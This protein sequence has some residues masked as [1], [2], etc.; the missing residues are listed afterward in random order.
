MS[1]ILPWLVLSL[2]LSAVAQEAGSFVQAGST[3]VSAMMVRRSKLV[4]CVI[5]PSTDVSR[6][7]R[8]GLHPRQDR[9]QR[10]PNRRPS[11]VGFSLVRHLSM[12]VVTPLR[13]TF[14]RNINT[15]QATT[16]SVLTNTF[17]ASG[18]HLPNG[19]YATFGG[20]AA[21][22]IGAHLALVLSMETQIL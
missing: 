18:M 17:C 15:H 16:M 14:G 12:S 13:R 4:L 21:I 3:L 10:R 19:S 7:R 11:R 1:C 6:Q 22:S 20:N 8:D 9:G 5:H 2:S